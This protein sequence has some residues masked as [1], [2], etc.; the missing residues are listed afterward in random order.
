V[1][2]ITRSRFGSGIRGK[3]RLVP[4]EVVIERRWL[5][6]RPPSLKVM[7]H[8]TKGDSC[9]GRSGFAALRLRESLVV[10]WRHPFS[11]LKSAGTQGFGIARATI[12]VDG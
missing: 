10:G 1:S 7:P 11:R 4:V 3:T 5:R 8:V 9:V 6:P 2:Q 12:G